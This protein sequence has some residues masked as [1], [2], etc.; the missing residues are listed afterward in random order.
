[1]YAYKVFHNSC[2]DI[3]KVEVDDNSNNKYVFVDGQRINV[4]GT[5]YKFFYNKEEAFRYKAKTMENNIK[6]LK[7]KKKEINNNLRIYTNELM[8][9]NDEL[10]KLQEE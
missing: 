9:C 1:M 2:I 8:I 10:I 6:K 3:R 7:Q 4:S 5:T